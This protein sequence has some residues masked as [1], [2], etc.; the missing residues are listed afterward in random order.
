MAEIKTAVRLVDKMSRPLQ[1]ISQQVKELTHSF[2]ALNRVAM[3]GVTNGTIQSVAVNSVRVANA[4]R[5]MT[6]ATQS[7]TQAMTAQNTVMVANTQAGA[8]LLGKFQLLTASLL[9]LGSVKSLLTMTDNLTNIKSRIDL[10]NDGLQTTE[11]LQNLIMESANNTFSSY[12][13]TA[14]MVGKLG[15]QA[16]EAFASNREIISFAEQINKHLAIAGTSGAAAQGAMIQLT[17]AM[18]NGVLR[19]EELNS[20]LDG[21]PTVVKAIRAE[22]ARMGDTRGIKEIAEEGLI[23]ADIVK[24]ALNNA[25]EETNK[26]FDAMSVTFTDVWNIFKN[27]SIKALQPLFDKLTE[28][29]NSKALITFAKN[30]ATVLGFVGSAVVGIF[31]LIEKVGSFIVTVWRYIAPVV[32]TILAPILAYKTALIAVWTWQ[33]IMAGA[34][35]IWNAIKLAIGAVQV[36]LMVLTG[37]QHA[38][39]AATFMFNSAWLASPVTWILLLIVAILASVISLVF[40][41]ADSWQEAVGIIAGAVSTLAVHIFNV[42]GYIYNITASV[43]EFFANVWMNPV[44]SV[45]KLFVNLTTNILDMC[46]AMTKGWDGFA[47]NMANGMIEAVNTVLGWWNKLVDALPDSVTESL[48]LGKATTIEYRTSITSDLEKIKGG[49]NDW[50]GD[51]PDNYWTAPKYQFKELSTAYNGGKQWGVDKA[52]KLNDLI[53]PAKMA[54]DATNTAGKLGAIAN[55][56]KDIANNTKGLN[57]PDENLEYLREI[58]EREAINKFTTAEIKVDLQ[59]TNNISNGMDIDGFMGMLVSKLTDALNTAAEGAH[60]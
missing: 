20:V 6:L 24:R 22:F 19:G 34:T 27:N 48:G 21:M 46:I 28:I 17:Q 5:Q 51:K 47:T 12:Q 40:Y 26:K 41:F 50:L 30:A 14:D 7:A 55:N 1:A 11:E 36:G 4:S 38:A 43:V 9:G 15:I 2:R 56:T 57:A 13:D 29:G 45:K 3:S 16:G 54:K 52:N 39:T 33:K 44:Y 49:L 31:N 42:F 60:R 32:Y 58:G 35:L 18:S 8:G 59:N 23:T 37:A 10:M 53:S 25:A